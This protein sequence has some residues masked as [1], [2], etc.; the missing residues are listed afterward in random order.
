[1]SDAGSVLAV[2]RDGGID[3]GTC[4]I[5]FRIGR[6]AGGCPIRI[7]LGDFKHNNQLTM[8][9]GSGSFLVGGC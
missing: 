6:L 4:P 2:V 7:H 3:A 5:R 8:V 1:M 9:V